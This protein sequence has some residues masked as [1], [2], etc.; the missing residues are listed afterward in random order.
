MTPKTT[1]HHHPPFSETVETAPL[2]SVSLTKLE[3]DDE[4]EALAFFRAA[5][6][7]GFFYLD[8]NDSELGEALVADAEKINE[9][10][11]EFFKIP[12]DELVEKYGTQSLDPFYAYRVKKF[13]IK[14]TDVIHINDTYNVSLRIVR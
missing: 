7:L 11:Q 3:Q 12:E 14:G 2:V 6:D 8:L 1:H 5:S 13:P 9:L 10:Q 4:D